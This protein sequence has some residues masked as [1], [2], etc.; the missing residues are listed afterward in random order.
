ME[1]WG[2]G[3]VCGSAVPEAAWVREV[4]E[5]GSARRLPGCS[6]EDAQRLLV[7]V[8]RHLLEEPIRTTIWTGGDPAGSQPLHHFQERESA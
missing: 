5:V 6:D 7:L 2:S 4:A 1:S 3:A 8:Y